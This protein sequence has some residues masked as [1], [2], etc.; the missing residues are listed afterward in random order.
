MLH[1]IKKQICKLFIIFMNILEYICSE[2]GKKV[3]LYFM[4]K[5]LFNIELC[6]CLLSNFSCIWLFATLWTVAHQASLSMGFSRQEYWN[7]LPCPSPGNI[8]LK[9][10]YLSSINFYMLIHL[11][12]STN[13]S[14]DFHIPCL[15]IILIK[16][17]YFC[18]LS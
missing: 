15:H 2:N 14:I 9:T 10:L 13:G 5:A 8:K 12:K 16:Y 3:M 11:L 4:F 1:V 6:A 17:K 18:I 7:K